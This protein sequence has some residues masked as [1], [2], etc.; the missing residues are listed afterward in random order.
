M[1]KLSI[2][3]LFTLFILTMSGCDF[4]E[5]IIEDAMYTVT[6][7]DDDTVLETRTISYYDAVDYNEAFIPEKEGYTF[8]GWY[9]DSN[10]NNPYTPY[11]NYEKD[12]SL[13]AKW[14]IL[15]FDVSVL[16]TMDGN[17]S[18]YSLAYGEN[19]SSIDIHVEG[20]NLVGFIDTDNDE[21]LELDT[22]VTS[23]LNLKTVF[24]TSAGY[25]LVQFVY[26]DTILFY[27]VVLDANELTRPELPQ[28]D[29]HLFIG[30][31]MDRE[32]N[33]LYYFDLLVEDDLTLY[34]KFIE[35]DA[36]TYDIGRS[37]LSWAPYLYAQ[38]YVVEIK[39]DGQVTTIVGLSEASI[40]LR[41]YESI[42]KDGATLHIYAQLSDEET[43]KLF[44][45]TLQFVYTNPMYEEDFEAEDFP[46]RTNYSN[47]INPRIDGPTGFEYAILNG[48]AS[49]T[50]PIEGLKTVQLRYN[51]NNIP[52]LESTFYLDNIG[53]IEVLIKNEN[54]GVLLE[55]L[56]AD[57]V[58]L[59]YFEI[60]TSSKPITLTLTANLTEAARLRFK[61]IPLVDGSESLP[62]YIDDIKIYQTGQVTELIEIEPVF[63]PDPDLEAIMA[64]FA[65]DRAKLTPPG[66]NALSEDGIL[67]YYASLNGLSGEAFRTE[68]T[69]ILTSTHRR[70]ISY[71]EARFVLEQS[72][73]VTVGDKRYL[74]GIYSGHEIIPYWDGGATWAREHVWP[75]SRLAMDRVTA[76][77]RNQGSDVHNLRAINPSVNSSR[78]NRY[79]DQGTTFGLVGT[80]AYYP[81]DTYKGDVARILFYMLARY[82]DILTLRDDNIVDS[83]YT[84]EGAVM[85]ILSLLLTWHKQDPVSDFERHRNEV[86]YTYQGNRNPFIDNPE[87]VD[88]Y[89]N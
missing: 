57:D 49:L 51:N 40:D 61:V 44:D 76:S 11:F 39:H 79:F 62:V 21:T 85:G 70:L 78:S 30:W 26:E 55:L 29:D 68:L 53:M 89:F 35:S 75:N 63:T 84:K 22:I 46:S 88:V 87:Y 71:N 81:G 27:E 72:D 41:D 83:A 69:Q 86:I 18:I 6:F 48:S 33:A 32:F 50:T 47:N 17:T 82:P 16:N 64:L 5:I 37:S 52:Y 7:I 20:M 34:A 24:E 58:V 12:L 38:S 8:D 77:G 2:Y 74:D 73:L 67:Q 4:F 28:M 23:D 36:Y 59:K 9:M 42:L 10:Y 3:L 45:V 80:E 66:F 54:Q 14:S 65:E 19:L 56:N 13:Y 1:K 43:L 25:H 60:D 15:M 31:Y